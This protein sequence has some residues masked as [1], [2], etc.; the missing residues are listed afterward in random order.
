MNIERAC[1][2]PYLRLS[3]NTKD[4]YKPITGT[5]KNYAYYAY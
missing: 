2:L 1:L 4:S 5:I 3:R